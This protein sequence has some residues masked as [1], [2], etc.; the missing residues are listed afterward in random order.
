MPNAR[1][2]QG[3]A[4]ESVLLIGNAGSGKTTQFRTLPGR[5]FLYIFDPNAL[6]SLAGA[7]IEYE[8]FLPDL[9]D[10]NV[11]PLAKD[12]KE[13]KGVKSEEPLS[14]PQW[15]KHFDDAYAS[16]YF[17]QFDWIGMDSFTTFSDAVMDRVQ[18]LN[19]R[20]GKHPEQADWTSQMMTIQ[21]VFRSLAAMDK[22]F[23][24][25]A[26]EEWKQDDLTKKVWCQP[27]MTGR[28]RIRIPLLFSNMFRC[29]AEDGRW[30]FQTTADR[31]H[32]YMRTSIRGLKPE[33]DVTIE[34]WDHPTRSGLGAILARSGR[35]NLAGGSVQLLNKAGA[36]N[37]A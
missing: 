13:T 1:D 9:L 11:H 15:E 33:E 35:L 30:F 27:V 36:H 25:T 21:S 37:K 7:D 8:A 3:A 2:V 32:D 12:K 22:L 5:G 18:Y 24:A 10:I 23:V 14:Y 28:L 20:F 16:G 29:F 26:H 34:D 6:A 31:Q 4:Y 17:D 19:G